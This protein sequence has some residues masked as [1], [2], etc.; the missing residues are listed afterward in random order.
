[1]VCNIWNL[2]V[3]IFR[4]IFIRIGYDYLCF[5]FSYLDVVIVE[6]DNYKKDYMIGSLIYLL[7]GLYKKNVLMLELVLYEIL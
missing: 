5:F 2:N 4:Y 6:Y 1:M 3:G 7:F